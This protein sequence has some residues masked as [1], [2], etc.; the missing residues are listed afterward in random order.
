MTERMHVS[1]SNKLLKTFEEPPD[2]TLIFIFAERY[3]LLLPTVRSRAQ[4]VKFDKLPEHILTDALIAHK[5]LEPEQARDISLI[6]E[7]NWNL[8]Q[9]IV[10]HADETQENFLKFREWLRLCFRPGNYLELNRFNGDISRSGRENIK[11]F[12]SYGMEIIH[13]SILQNTGRYDKVKKSGDEL[14]FLKK[15]APYINSSNQDGIYRLLNESI[16]HIERN[17]HAGILF[18]DISFKLGYLLMLGRKQAAH[19]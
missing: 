11:R 15:F 10:E 6:S 4:L 19:Q 3:E 8:A 12:L 2:K 7:G 14:V 16:Y 17:A 9:E 13:N 1:A 18:S 5:N